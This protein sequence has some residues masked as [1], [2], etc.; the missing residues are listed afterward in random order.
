MNKKCM[1]DSDYE[2]KGHL[3]YEIFNQK[4]YI[5]LKQADGMFF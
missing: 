5:L 4:C 1:S 3:I 2:R